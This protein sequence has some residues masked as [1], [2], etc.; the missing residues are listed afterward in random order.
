[1]AR[2]APATGGGPSRCVRPVIRLRVPSDLCG[3]GSFRL[4]LRH[5]GP[6]QAPRSEVMQVTLLESDLRFA[7]M[8]GTCRGSCKRC[9]D[10][11][12]AGQ[13]ALQLGEPAHD[14]KVEVDAWSRRTASGY[15]CA[16]RC[17]RDRWCPARPCCGAC[18]CPRGVCAGGGTAGS[19]SRAAQR[20]PRP[21]TGV[22]SGGHSPPRPEAIS[23][24][25]PC[26]PWAA[27]G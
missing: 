9:D 8:K 18:L 4:T 20:S 11:L 17:S 7:E 14:P 10:R 3:W 13:R 23:P 27:S 6:V 22:P 5:C 12:S 25:P 16:H 15:G 24:S 1:M 2:A 26:V 19:G 21:R